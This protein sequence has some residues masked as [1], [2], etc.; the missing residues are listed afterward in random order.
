MMEHA[1]TLSKWSSS[2]VHEPKT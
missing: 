2:N 1:G